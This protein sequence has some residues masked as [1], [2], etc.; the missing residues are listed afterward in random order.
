MPIQPAAASG[1]EGK[2]E[3][4]G[5]YCLGLQ[6]LE[7]F[8]HIIILYHL[9]Q[10]GSSRLKVIPFLDTQERGVFATRAP[11]RP[12]PI[13]LS[14]VELISRENNILTVKN[15]DILDG[16]PLIDIKPYIEQFDHPLQTKAGWYE[17]TQGELKTT[18]ADARFKSNLP[19]T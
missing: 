15:I 6:D 7:G 2:I 9:H 8:S 18:T 11:V 3:V 16:T 13:G 4:F 19:R 12:N 5:E 1:T 17:K 14:I 10:V